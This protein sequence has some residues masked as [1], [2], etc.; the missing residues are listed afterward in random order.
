MNHSIAYTGNVEPQPLTGESLVKHSI[1]IDAR[2]GEALES[3]ARINFA[4]IYAVEH[5]VK[6][7]RVGKVEDEYLEWVLHYA[8]ESSGVS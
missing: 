3:S 6:V 5:N 4:E 8:K 2:S 1:K 7:S